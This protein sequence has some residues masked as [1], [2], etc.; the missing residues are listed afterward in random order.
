MAEVASGTV[1]NIKLTSVPSKTWGGLV[2]RVAQTGAKTGIGVAG[3]AGAG[4]VTGEKPTAGD[5]AESGVDS[6]I[7]LLIPDIERLA[8]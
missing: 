8:F 3:K 5:K 7:D 2:E 6:A 1:G 4:M